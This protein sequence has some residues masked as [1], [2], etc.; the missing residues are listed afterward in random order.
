MNNSVT[1]QYIILITDMKRVIDS[2]IDLEYEGHIFDE[3]QYLLD[4][5]IEDMPTV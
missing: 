4:R 3:A 5:F 1:E 2:M